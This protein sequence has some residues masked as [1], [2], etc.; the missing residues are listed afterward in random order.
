[1]MQL[2]GIVKTSHLCDS[3]T[4]VQ[5]F[6]KLSTGKEGNKH[7]KSG[8]L[9]QIAHNEGSINGLHVWQARIRQAQAPITTKCHD[10]PAYHQYIWINF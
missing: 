5:D 7:D 2:N 8:K 9:I 1:M 3:V 6:S 10:L 4:R